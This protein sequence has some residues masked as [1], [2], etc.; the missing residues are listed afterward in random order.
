LGYY[1]FYTDKE[2]PID[3][4]VPTYT[5]TP[6]GSVAQRERIIFDINEWVNDPD[7]EQHRD[8]S[9]ES[10]DEGSDDMWGFTCAP[11][12]ANFSDRGTPPCDC[13]MQ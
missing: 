6:T 3:A 8:S 7:R 1:E 5:F 4:T 2:V 11:V 10:Q 9:D 13:A 12:A